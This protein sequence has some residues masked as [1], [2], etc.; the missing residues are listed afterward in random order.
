MC[1]QATVL[2]AILPQGVTA[3]QHLYSHK[4]GK[5]IKHIANK[6]VWQVYLEYMSR[7]ALFT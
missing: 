4:Q 7:H 3:R 5:L 2:Q 1:Q 6:P